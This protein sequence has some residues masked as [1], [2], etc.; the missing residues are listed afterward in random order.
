[1]LVVLFLPAAGQVNNLVPVDSGVFVRYWAITAHASDGLQVHAINFYS[2]KASS[3]AYFSRT[4]GFA[5]RLASRED[6]QS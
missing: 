6:C 5:I 3:G 4:R 2:T 1:M